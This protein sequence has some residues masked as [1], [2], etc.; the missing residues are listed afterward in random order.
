[1]RQLQSGHH[2]KETFFVTTLVRQAKMLAT[3]TIMYGLNRG[4]N[5]LYCSYNIATERCF[6]PNILCTVTK[7][8]C[9][10]CYSVYIRTYVYMH[11]RIG[12]GQGV[13]TPPFG[14]LCRLF[15]IG[16]KI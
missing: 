8:H 15:N 16:P 5:E 13:R 7:H 4:K 6:G 1:M 11:G 9:D 10:I 14:P 12:G 2:I 3:G